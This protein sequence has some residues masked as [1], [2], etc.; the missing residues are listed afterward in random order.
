MPLTIFTSQLLDYIIA[1]LSNNLVDLYSS[2]HH[3]HFSASKSLDIDDKFNL[4]Y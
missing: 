3:H 4:L 1:S 2:H